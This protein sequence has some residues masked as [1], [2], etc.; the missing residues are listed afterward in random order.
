MTR[1]GG[2]DAAPWAVVHFLY[3]SPNYAGQKDNY[4]STT[5]YTAWSFFPIC[6]FENFRIVTNIYFLLILIIS[7]LPWSPVSYM[8]NLIPLIFVLAVSMI[9]T[10]IEELMKYKQDKI[11]NSTPVQI[12]KNGEWVDSLSKDIQSG[13]LVKQEIDA[14]VAC[15]MLYITSSNENQICNYS[16]AQLNGES[17]V[18]TMSPHKAFKGKSI[19]DLFKD[20]AYEIHLTEP[21]RDLFK[22][23][24]KLVG[25][26]GAIY[27]VAIHNIL[28]RGMTI[29]YTDWIMGIALTTG[30]D[31][32]VM[33]NQRHPPS[34]IT[35]FDKDINRMIAL[36]FLFKMILIC[37]LAGVCSHYETHGQFPD[38]QRVAPTQSTC[39]GVAF[40]QNFVNYSYFIPISL[41]VTI[42]IIRFIHMF[43]ILLDDMLFD[44]YFGGPEPHNSNMIGQL[45]LVTH[46]LSDKTGTLTENIMQLV[47]FV[48]DHGI[49]VA[50]EFE[51]KD[52]K[53][54]EKS[55][56]FLLSLA[57]CNTVIVYISPTGEV[58]YN[59]ESPDEAAFVE[60]AANC[61]FKLLDRK[62]DNFSLEIFG[63]KHEYKIISILPFNSDR[64]RMS[65]VIQ[66][67]DNNLVVYT[68]GADNIIYERVVEAK[69]QECV[70]QF[71]VEGLRTLVFSKRELT[72]EEGD[73]WIK[74]FTDAS[75]EINNRDEA[76]AAIAPFVESQLECLGISAVED[77]LQ[78]DVPEAIM[79]LRKADV[80]FWVLTGDKLETAIEIGKT[81]RVILPESDMLVVSQETDDE[82]KTQIEQYTN[83]FEDFND[84]VLILTA[85]ATELILTKLTDLFLPLALSCQ[86][87]IFS[88][89]SPFQ[90]ASIVALVKK[91]PGTLT[92]AIGDG[93]NDV[94]MLQE[95][96]VGIGVM[97]REGSQ[98][99]QSSDFAIPRFRHLIQMMAVHGHWSNN[100]FTH[101]ASFMLYKNFCFI[102][103]F[104]WSMVDNLA[105]P[106]PFYDSLLISC[107]NLVFTLLP[108]FA[109]GIFERDMRKCDL[110]KYPHVYRN[111]RNPMHWPHVIYYFLLAIYQSIIVYYSVRLGC[112]YDSLLG[113]GTLAYVCAVI[114]VTIQMC[115]WG[116]DW[117]IF[118]D[119]SFIITIILLFLVIIVYVFG[120]EPDKSGMITETFGTIRGWCSLVASVT[121][122]IL[123]P[124]SGEFLLAH[125]NPT[126]D[127]LIIERESVDKDTTLDFKQ[128]IGQISIPQA[129]Q[130]ST[131]EK[132]NE[133]S[134]EETELDDIPPENKESEASI[135]ASGTI[136]K[137]EV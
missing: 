35:Q 57:I 22:F 90:K 96:H 12:Y 49:H 3:P 111:Q 19:P 91:Q 77:K 97:G 92:L 14:M 84:P 62:P 71:A 10:G 74:D 117:N 127:R 69:Y 54:I 65:V 133:L 1:V 16:E 105:S 59:A 86:S 43:F 38:V 81:S 50:S 121:L 135:N 58:E 26:N 63:E 89:V 123:P 116:N 70:N 31:C 45:G 72:K 29:H 109:Y 40:L 17:A 18:K 68:K 46:V 82:V 9:K 64:K 23:D 48:D 60:F 33:K 24:C 118:L 27:P 20:E 8:F 6:L 32:K 131:E 101:V 122:S 129:A 25:P 80:A 44:D 52:K 2:I 39:L 30:H 128:N 61:G 87:V 34:K 107:F 102:I 42:E 115:I 88:R 132:S 7:C 73:K 120:I 104:M 124:V 15:D 119:L 113:N 66:E 94:G 4:I 11:K 5:R 67:G 56:E 99:A 37:I 79:W 95:S 13:D 98:A 126:L 112:P 106:V 93:A 75:N 114:V 137:K 41:M 36:I 85:H 110:L 130:E 83:Q 134:D 78:P 100:R 53:Q 125:L 21:T 76:I 136:S 28:L 55:K 47:N 108:P 103:V 51:K